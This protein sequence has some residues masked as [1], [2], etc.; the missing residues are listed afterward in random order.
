MKLY[1]PF[2]KV[3][4][5]QRLVAGYASTEALDSQNE[6]VKREALRDALQPYMK[7]A[8]IR[9][10]HGPSAVGI[11]HEAEMDD[12][13]LYLSA[14]IVDPLAWEKVRTGVYKGFSIGG[15]VTE[16]DPENRH[17]ITG[18]DLSEISLVDR[19]ANPEALFDVWKSG[20]VAEDLNKDGRRNSADD[21]KHL[22]AAHDALVAA[23]AECPGCADKGLG[24][25]DLAKRTQALAAENA[26]LKAELTLLKA[27]PE[28]MK[29]RVLAIGKG[30]DILLG[31]PAAAA[32]LPPHHEK[33]FTTTG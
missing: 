3:D 29:G 16:R 22:N 11:A 13:G 7:F 18:L 20:M 32:V 33:W 4:A 9:E 8:N 24:A 25:G 2:A 23:G 26:T 14:R 27:R 30:D 6:I 17:I 28:P 1:A 12:K 15:R 19:P 5:E 31:P 21:Q 10:M